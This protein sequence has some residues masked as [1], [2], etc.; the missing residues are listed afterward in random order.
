M[1]VA[2]RTRFPDPY[3]VMPAVRAAMRELD[4][5]IPAFRVQTFEEVVARSLWRQRLQGEV[6]GVFAVLALL[7]ASVGLYGVIAYAVTQRTRE[8][9]VRVALGA[10]RGQVL[11]LV[12]GH[13]VR[14]TLIGVAIG[15]VGAL[16]LS[17][18]IT[19]LL[20]GVT[21]TDPATFVAVP[22]VLSAVAVLAS[23]APARRAMRVDPLVAMRAE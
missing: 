1:T 3:A 20:Y 21:P 13:G 19:S 4:A 10:T 2:I 16:A 23:Y 15:A 18:L 7:L 17:R 12:L 9:G 5:A 11:G 22:A 14:L 8:L 6:L